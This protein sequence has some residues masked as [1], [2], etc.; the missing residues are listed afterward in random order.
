MALEYNATVTLR[1]DLAPDTMALRVKLD[2]EAFPFEAGQYT[3]LGL[4]RSSPRTGEAA[5]ESP[6]MMAKPADHMIRRA[7]SITSNS[8]DDEL[9]FVVTLVRSGGLSPRLFALREGSRIYVHGAAQGIFTLDASSGNRDLLLVATG[10][11]LAPYLSM[12]RTSF[13]ETEEIK[14]VVVHAAGTS[15]DLAFRTQMEE[16]A[17]ATDRLTYIPTVTRPDLDPDWDGL[18]APVEQLLADGEIEDA[19]GM[20]VAPEHYDVF[21]SGAPDMI[22]TV[23]AALG[24]AG[25]EAEDIHAE[26]YW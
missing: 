17:A 24:E 14:Y 8:A 11:A 16:M 18:T 7:Y 25:F 5:A 1:A 9:E 20:P 22:K 15:R 4:L 12:I 21:L 19:V 10:S 6:E 13:S 23:T 3:V 26:R 2:G